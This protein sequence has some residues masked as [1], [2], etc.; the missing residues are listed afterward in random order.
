MGAGVENRTRLEGG[1]GVKGRAGGK[2]VPVK[3]IGMGEG[4][5]RGRGSWG[6]V[7]EG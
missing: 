7:L 3:S 2:A 6:H 1:D 5:D 4:V